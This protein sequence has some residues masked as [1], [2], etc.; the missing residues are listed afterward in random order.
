MEVPARVR[1]SAVLVFLIGLLVIGVEAQSGV[2][3]TVAA[4]PIVSNSVFSGFS[5]QVLPHTSSG[6]V[7]M[8]SAFRTPFGEFG[9]GIYFGSRGNHPTRYFSP[10]Y[11]PCWDYRWDPLGGLFNHWLWGC[12]FFSGLAYR[13]TY[14]PWDRFLVWNSYHPRP[15]RHAFTYWRDPFIPPWGPHWTQDPWAPFW[16]GYWDEPGFGS[17]S[18]ASYPTVP[19]A[20]PER[21]SRTA[22]RRPSSRVGSPRGYGD[23][24][25]RPPGRS[26]V[27]R[28]SS[29]PSRWPAIPVLDSQDPEE[30]KAKSRAR[31][32]RPPPSD[33]LG[34]PSDHPSLDPRRAGRA[35]RGITPR[36]SRP[37]DRLRGGAVP[38]SK[39][40]PRV[41]PKSRNR[42]PYPSFNRNPADGNGISNN[43][44]LGRRRSPKAQLRPEVSPRTP[45]TK[46]ASNRAPRAAPSPSRAP[47]AQ[48]RPRTS[49]K[50][51]PKPPPQPSRPSSIA[52]RARRPGN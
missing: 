34:P 17:N 39:T 4:S 47:R 11:S 41:E 22:T 40:K 46:P 20:K 28:N 49:P 50:A 10:G 27:P 26:A 3:F 5:L 9:Y 30:P 52:R 14:H 2:S 23:G 35:S 32:L 48:A 31:G 13:S 44:S 15:P 42:S 18:P 37:S 43:P 25:A 36:T 45:Q 19:D 24:T 7:R 29:P 33:L 16:D 21:P 1:A 12:D 51:S 6:Y 8:G 38:D